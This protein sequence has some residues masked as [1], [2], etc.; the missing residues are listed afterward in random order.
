VR[1][2]FE[3]DSAAPLLTVRPAKMMR[4][5][6]KHMPNS[7]GRLIASVGP[8]RALLTQGLAPVQ[9]HSSG[10][11]RHHLERRAANENEQKRLDQQKPFAW[12]L[13]ATGGALFLGNYLGIIGNPNLIVET[14]C[15][16][17]VLMGG[18]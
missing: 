7:T 3:L 13:L 1:L 8:L 6:G 5:R 9:V 15:M 2:L 14:I 10:M 4:P 18:F 11:A 16:I 17:V 12:L